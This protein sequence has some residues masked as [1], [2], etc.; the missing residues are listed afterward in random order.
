MK[1]ETFG[2]GV[3]GCGNIC[4]TYFKN[5]KKFSFIEVRA[6][7]DIDRKRADEKALEFGIAKA[8]SVKEILA[9]DSIDII[10]NLTIP[11]VHAEINLAAL[12]AGKHVYCEKPL[13]ITRADALKVVQLAHKKRLLV[14][15][16]PDTVL[17]A[18]IQTCKKLIEDG[19]IGKPVAA[20]AFMMGHGPEAWHPNPF[21][22][23]EKGA[24]PLFDMGPYYITALLTLL[25]P[26][27]T[28][29][30]MAIKGFSERLVTCKEHFGEKITVKTPTHVAGN[31]QFKSGA[32]G[33]LITSF[34]VWSSSLPRIEIY[35][36]EGTISVP[37]PNSFGGPAF[38][39]R[40][41]DA[42]RKEV[43]LAFGY[44]ES[45]RGL[46]LADM[47]RSISTGRPHRANDALAYHTVEI[48]EG[49]L[50]SSQKKEFYTMKSTFKQP[51]MFPTGL[52]DGMLD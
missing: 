37:D 15:C 50:E 14:G 19:W 31:L 34:D 9:D 7:A 46:G 48:M 18:G 22:F 44:S 1:K 3:I 2:V 25:G 39:K 10:L 27:D 11:A 28:I 8:C 32:V 45:F 4:G 36:T 52:V 47:A 5:L 49:M 16:A 42:E 17:G 51:E 6:C 33:T 23:Y 30:S 43:S 29:A 26:V 35:G 20:T 13:A 41:N 24:G 12:M 38:L 40:M 21:F